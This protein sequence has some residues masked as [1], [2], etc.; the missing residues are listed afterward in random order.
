MTA[1]NHSRLRHRPWKKFNANEVLQKF[2][3]TH[4]IHNWFQKAIIFKQVREAPSTVP[5]L[6][7]FEKLS[8]AFERNH[9]GPQ[10]FGVTVLFFSA[11]LSGSF[12][13][14]CRGVSDREL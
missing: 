4:Q 5:N 3:L 9:S 2:R 14:P 10:E 7:E 1:D 12:I 6:A 11:S 8:F 13:L